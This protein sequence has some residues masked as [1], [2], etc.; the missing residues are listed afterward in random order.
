[1]ELFQQNVVDILGGDDDSII[2]QFIPESAIGRWSKKELQLTARGVR[3]QVAVFAATL[4][5]L[6]AQFL[7]S[8]RYYL[9]RADGQPETRAA[10]DPL[11]LRMGNAAFQLFQT[12]FRELRYPVLENLDDVRRLREDPLLDEYRAV[13]LDYSMRISDQLDSGRVAIL[14][15]FQ[16][17]LTKTANDFIRHTGKMASMSSLCFWLSVPLGILGALAHLSLSLG[18]M[19]FS[20]YA[21][22]T[23]RDDVRWIAFGKPK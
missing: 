12:Q 22:I 21:R 5:T 6:S 2:D 18:I 7:S 16:K 19:P 20:A 1:L 10:P 9:F 13:L 4:G 15:E 3:K 11:Y 17:D 8:E 23:K 14:E